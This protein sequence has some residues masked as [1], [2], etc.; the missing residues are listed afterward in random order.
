MA[1]EIK[2]HLSKE[3][4]P[5]PW[6]PHFRKCAHFPLIFTS[7][8]IPQYHHCDN[9]AFLERLMKTGNPRGI[10]SQPLLVPQVCSWQVTIPYYWTW[11]HNLPWLLVLLDNLDSDKT[12][13]TD[14]RGCLGQQQHRLWLNTVPSHLWPSIILPEIMKLSVRHSPLSVCVCGGG[15]R[16]EGRR[17]G[18]RKRTERESVQ[19][20]LT[21]ALI[22]AMMWLWK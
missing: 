21:V 17:G 20:L 10:S 2:A 19:E 22:N 18:R 4:D 16:K 13:G 12:T 9:T 3:S 6:C 7:V 14:A 11:P 1:F 5:Y 15:G 8:L